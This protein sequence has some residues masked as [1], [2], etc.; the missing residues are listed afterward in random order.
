[1]A[2]PVPVFPEVGSTIVPPGR[3]LPSRSAASISATATRSLIE[4]PGLSISTLATTS[5]VSPAARRESRTSGVSPIASRIES[6]MVARDAVTGDM[7]H[8]QAP[9]RRRCHGAAGCSVRAPSD[10]TTCGTAA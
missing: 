5:G 2:R 1:M 4:P 6:L 8:S 3:S 9:V 10:R 7:A